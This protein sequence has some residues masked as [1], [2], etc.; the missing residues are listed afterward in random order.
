VQQ[1]C[2]DQD[3]ATEICSHVL[4]VVTASVEVQQAGLR[5]YETMIAAHATSHRI[6]VKTAVLA[7]TD[8]P[9]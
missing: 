7:T 4:D 9:L 2:E 1:P 3:A 5:A 8:V 6:G